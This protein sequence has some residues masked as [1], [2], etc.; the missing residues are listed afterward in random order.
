MKR[1]RRRKP[2]RKQVRR[3][4]PR[5]VGIGAQDASL[6]TSS[7]VVALAES[8]DNLDVVGVFNR[9]VGAIKQPARGVGAGELLVALAP[10]Q[11]LGGD[12]LAALDRQR[13]DVATTELSAV[14]GIPA[15]TAG[16]LA[17][18]FGAQQFVGIEAAS[19]NWSAEPSGCCRPSAGW[20]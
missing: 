17:R 1:V 4:V 9:A 15:T 3:H 5:R 14:P 13:A 12:A 2:G 10:S 16:A 7:G 19:A 6:T 18:R 11:L 8:V 20:R